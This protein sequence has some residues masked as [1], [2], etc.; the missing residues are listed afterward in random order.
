[1]EN[2]NVTLEQI[3]LLMERAQVSYTDAKEALERTNG[4]ILEALL[5]LE[6]E[7]KI[8]TTS[9]SSESM[10]KVSS[11]ID[12]LN[13]TRFKMRKNEKVYVNIPLSI[14][15]ILAVLTLHISII[16]LLISIVL[17]IKIELEG[18]NDIVEKVNSAMDTIQK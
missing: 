3:D 13:Q 6:K 14:A 12:K 4:D 11:F 16:G 15:I 8:K 5:L 18:N 17:G 10:E 9:S 1:M 7:K 2:N